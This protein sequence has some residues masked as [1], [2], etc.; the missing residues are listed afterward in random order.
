[1]I[2]IFDSG[3]GGVSVFKEILKLNP[4]YKY[5]YYSDSLNNP[6]GEKNQEELYVITKKIVKYLIDKGCKI[7]VIACNTASLMCSE[8]LRKEFSIPI[9][10][11]EPAWKIIYNKN[12]LGKALILA[13]KGTIES[14][15]FQ[16]LSHNLFQDNIITYECIG[17]AELIEKDKMDFIENYLINNLTKYKDFENIVLGCTHYPLILNKF[18]N[19]FPKATFY[20]GSYGVAKKLKTVIEEKNLKETKQEIIFVDSSKDIDKQKRFFRILEDKHE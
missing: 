3:I 7:I 1:M 10:A 14:P 19:F 8:L 18:L 11:I 15:K 9:I 16:D 12:C 6:Y 17:L 2:G 4:N 13:T 5:I 20:D